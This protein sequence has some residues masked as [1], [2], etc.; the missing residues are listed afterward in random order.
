MSMEANEFWESLYSGMN[1]KR[2]DNRLSTFR[3]NPKWPKHY[4]NPEDLAK[5]GFFYFYVD[6]RV[7]CA[8][9]GGDISNWSPGDEPMREHV[10]HFSTCPFVMGADVG[11]VPSGDDPFPGPKRPY[12]YDVCGMHNPPQQTN[13]SRPPPSYPHQVRSNPVTPP[14]ARQ[15]RLTQQPTIP[16]TL[17]D[18]IC[19]P[20]N[21]P[22]I[23]SQSQ[24]QPQSQQILS[25]ASIRPSN[26]SDVTRHGPESSN[27]DDNRLGICKICFDKE[28]GIVFGPCGHGT[29]TQCSDYL[30]NCPICRSPIDIRLRTYL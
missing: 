30:Y 28:V 1:M 18:V 9:C 23:R 5:A 7:A 14:N 4:I 29:C 13:T 16:T 6:D 12:P 26:T 24:Q 2:E 20:T 10:K 8:F 3:R 19:E 17:P 21:R 15:T 22:R 11:N 27:H 25:Q